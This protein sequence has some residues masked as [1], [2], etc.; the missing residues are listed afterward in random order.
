M[1]GIAPESPASGARFVSPLSSEAMVFLYQIPIAISIF[2]KW[3][4]AY[5]N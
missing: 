1:L 3:R 2:L 4:L 5:R